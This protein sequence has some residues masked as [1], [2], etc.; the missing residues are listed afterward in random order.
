[1]KFRS[2]SDNS[3]PM[4]TS[5]ENEK[6]TSLQKCMTF[7]VITFWTK[8]KKISLEHGCK[9]IL[10]VKSLLKFIHIELQRQSHCNIVGWRI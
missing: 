1:M 5:N 4:F 6:E 3:K 8:K 2:S 10:E 7:L 9:A